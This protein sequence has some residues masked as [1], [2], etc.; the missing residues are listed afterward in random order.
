VGFEIS[1][2]FEAWADFAK[3]LYKFWVLTAF[4]N[5]P[6][7]QQL[8]LEFKTVK[9]YLEIAGSKAIQKG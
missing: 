8:F 9:L 5:S 4:I 7:L 6:T 3:A 1:T 2:D